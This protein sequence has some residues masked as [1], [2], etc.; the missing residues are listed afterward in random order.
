MDH[1]ITF[2]PLSARD[3]ENLLNCGVVKE[4]VRGGKVVAKR[5]FVARQTDV[6]NVELWLEWIS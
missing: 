6:V 1:G 3:A 4:I 5:R 2:D